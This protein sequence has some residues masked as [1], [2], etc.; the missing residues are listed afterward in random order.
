MHGYGEYHCI[1]GNILY[2]GMFEENLYYGFG[3]LRNF[4]DDEIYVGYWKKH[5]KDGIGKTIRKNSITLSRYSKNIVIQN[6][7]DQ[8]IIEIL[9]HDNHRHLVKFFEFSIKELKKYVS[10]ARILNPK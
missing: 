4:T 1:E 6:F 2:I 10:L 9:L 5:L 3:I 8:N 7:D